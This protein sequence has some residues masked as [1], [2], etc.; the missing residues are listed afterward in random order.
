MEI[1]GKFFTWVTFLIII[2]IVNGFVLSK[3][4]YWFIVQTFDIKPITLIQAVGLS[5]IIGY[6]TMK[7][8]MGEDKKK[9]FSEIAS[10]WFS[11]IIYNFMVLFLGY[12]ISLFM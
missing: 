8:N 4:W 3:L 9:D 12:I 6:L 2:I 1:I 10:D 11:I 5:L 7:K